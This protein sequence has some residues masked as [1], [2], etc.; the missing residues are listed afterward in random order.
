MDGALV[1][2]ASP[3]QVIN[4]GKYEITVSHELTLGW[5]PRAKDS[6]WVMGGCIILQTGEDEFYIAGTGIACTFSLIGNDKEMVGIL[7]SDE[8]NFINSKWVAGRRMNGDQDHQ[9]RHVRIPDNEWGIQ[10]VKLYTYK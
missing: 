2:K 10:K 8:G 6:T 7:R 1:E 3:K 5:S 9:G 4:M